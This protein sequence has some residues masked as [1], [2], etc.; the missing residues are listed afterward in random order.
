MPNVAKARRCNRV[1]RAMGGLVLRAIG[2]GLFFTRLACAGATSLSRAQQD[3]ERA[4]KQG[5]PAR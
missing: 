5:G 4:R 2:W 1:C 3:V